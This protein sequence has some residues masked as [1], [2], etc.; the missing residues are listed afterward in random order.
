MRLP[1]YI[2]NSLD[3]GR[4][5]FFKN[6]WNKI[7]ENREL[8]Y[9]IALRNP[10]FKRTIIQCS[11]TEDEENSYYTGILNTL[12]EHCCGSNPLVIGMSSI[13]E[14]NDRIED[15]WI[16]WAL[17]NGI[18][19][20]IRTI[21][22]AAART[23]LGIALPCIKYD[24]AD[25]AKLAFK[26]ISYLDLET[27]R[28]A[29]RTD[30]IIDGVMYDKYWQMMKIYVHN[31]E[32]DEPTEYDVNDILVWHKTTKEGLHIFGPECGPALALY[33][34]I[35]RYM[36]A[37]IKG[38]EFRACTPMAMELDPAVW[39]KEELQDESAPRG[40]YQYGPGTVP[41]LPPGVKLSGLPVSISGEER[42]KFVE[43]VNGAAGRCIQ[44]PKNLALGDSSNHNMASS[45]FD[46]Q[47]WINKIN[48]DRADFEPI[49][50]K[51]F[52]LWVNNI[53]YINGYLPPIA[54]DMLV[55]GEFKY[56]FNY[57]ALFQ[58]PDPNKN[59]SARSTDLASG[60]TTLV[61]EYKK[62]G[63]NARRELKREADL[64]GITYEQLMQTILA[65]RTSEFMKIAGIVNEQNID[66]E[67]PQDQ[68]QRR[69]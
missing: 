9:N 60:S 39:G 62:L 25:Q 10:F 43:L 40:K 28:D 56:S 32:S 18:G 30:R 1:R 23:G 2:K 37:V 53:R 51:V 50:R 41:T 55:K 36:E 52:Q 16:N 46:M 7:P 57:D 27:P 66:Q 58:H 6:D 59:A 45:Q 65:S 64:Y 11:I 68:Q 34:S 44:M 26:T 48:I 67:D 21:R 69:V 47:P 13:N 31:E 3:W 14:V 20:T 33:P 22:R 49:P 8:A 29:A 63:M 38:E 12:S 42:V 24:S 15:A 61:R 17:C 5:F 4:S 54:I 19:S 35:K